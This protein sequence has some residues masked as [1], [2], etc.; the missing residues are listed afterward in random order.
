MTLI[1]FARTTNLPRLQALH[2]SDVL[3]LTACGGLFAVGI[4]ALPAAPPLATAV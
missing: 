3:Q 1:T 4:A 2:A